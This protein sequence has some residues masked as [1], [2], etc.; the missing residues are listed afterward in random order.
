MPEFEAALEELRRRSQPAPDVPADTTQQFV[1]NQTEIDT[2]QDLNLLRNQT[3]DHPGVQVENPR[4]APKPLSNQELATDSLQNNLRHAA[5]VNPQE[6]ARRRRLANDLGVP[7]ELLPDGPEAQEQL[8]LKE[9]DPVALMK[10]HPTIAAY[11]QDLDNAEVAGQD[12]GTLKKVSNL[13]RRFHLDPLVAAAKTTVAVPQTLAGVYKIYDKAVMSL[14]PDSLIKAVDD[15]TPQAIREGMGNVEDQLAQSG[16]RLDF[17]QTQ[18]FLDKFYSPET[19]AAKESVAKAEGFFGTIVTALENPSAIA[20][21]IGE[22]IGPMLLGGATAQVITKAFPAISPLVAGAAG[23]GVTIAGGTAQQITEETGEA[24]TGKQAAIAAGTGVLGAGIGILGAKIAQKLGVGDLDTALA[25]GTLE[26]AMVKSQVPPGLVK[27]ILVGG[28]LEGMEELGQSGVEQIAQNIATEKPWNEGIPEALAMG[29]LTGGV[30]GG[31]VQAI[32]P[33][34]PEEGLNRDIDD[35][36]VEALR[37]VAHAQQAEENKQ[38]LEEFSKSVA[39]SSL[40]ANSPE[41]FKKF[42]RTMADEGEMIQEVYVD[43]AKLDE[44]FA[45]SG[46]T[47]E[48]L[49]EKM[50]EVAKELALAKEVGSEVRI[51]F[52]DYA[53]HIAG[54]KAEVPLLDHLRTTPEGMTYAESQ[55]FFQGQEKQL[56]EQAKEILETHQPVLSEKEFKAQEPEGSYQK[57]L[58]DHKNKA[59]VFAVDTKNVHQNILDGLNATGRFTK[60]INAVYAVPFREFYATAAA[61]EG[62]LPSELYERMPLNFKNVRIEDG[63]LDQPAGTFTS[64][65]LDNLTQE[66]IKDLLVVQHNLSAE[67]LL[68]A[69]KMGGLAVPSVGIAKA[70]SPLKGFGEITLVGS[71]DLVRPSKDT[72]A[73]GADI[74][75]PRYPKVV[76]DFSVQNVKFLEKEIAQGIEL[77]GEGI[78][79]MQLDDDPVNTLRHNNAVLA[80]YLINIG[81]KPKIVRTKATKSPWPT[82]AKYAK[83]TRPPHVIKADEVFQKAVADTVDRPALLKTEGALG[84]LMT[85]R[86]NDLEVHRQKV[87]DAGKI[88]KMET[89]RALK[90]QVKDTPEFSDYVLGLIERAS[91]QEKLFKGYTY[92]GSRK[93]I[94]HTLDNVIKALKQDIRAAEGFN[95]GLGTARATVTPKFRSVEQIQANRNRIVDTETFEAIKEE[96]NEEFLALAEKVNE[97]HDVARFDTFAEVLTFVAKQG[98]P[99]SLEESGYTN[100]PVELQQEIGAFMDKLKNMPTEYFEVKLLR[101]VSLGEFSGAVVPSNTSDKVLA[102][103]RDN[104]IT[105][106]R[107]YKAGDTDARTKAIAKFNDLFFQNQRTPI[108]EQ[109]PETINVDG[110]ER[111]TT[112]SEGKQIHPT[113]EGV[114]NFWRWFGDSKV[115]DEAGKPLVVYHGTSG[116]FNEFN[117]EFQDPTIRSLGGFHFTSEPK[118]ARGFSAGDGG[119][120]IPVYLSASNLENLSREDIRSI[121]KQ[122]GK[123]G[124]D[125]LVNDKKSEGIDGFIID[126]NHYIVFDPNQIKSAVGNVGT[127]SETDL[128]ILRQSGVR[129][130]TQEE[131]TGRP[132]GPTTVSGIPPIN[133]FEEQTKI[134]GRDGQPLTV[135]RGSDA[136]LQIDHFKKEA[137]GFASGAAPSGRGVHFTTRKSSAA[138][139]GDVRE[140]QLDIRNPF[141]FKA[142]DPKIP[143]HDTAEE[144]FEWREGLRKKG[145]DGIVEIASHLGGPNNIIAFDPEQVILKPQELHQ[146]A[147]QDQTETEEFKNWSSNGEVVESED[148]NDYQFKPNT[149]TVLKV[150]HGTTHDFSVFEA[151]RGNLEG[152]FGAINYFTSSQQD[153]SDNYAGEGPDLTNRIESLSE[154]L[155]D[156][157]QELVEVDFSTLSLEDTLDELASRINSRFDIDLQPQDIPVE[158]ESVNPFALAEDVARRALSG[159]DEL[160]MELFVRVDNPFVIGGGLQFVELSADLQEEARKQVA[161]E[162]GI[163]LDELE[164]NIDD[165]EDA[166][167]ER[168]SELET[169]APNALVE[170]IQKVSSRYEVSAGELL[171]SVYELGAETDTDT[172]EDLLRNSEDYVYAEDPDTGQLVGSQLVAEV[173]KEMGFDSII[174]RNADTRFQGMDMEEGTAHV[175]IFDSGKTNIKS[176]ENVGTFDPTDPDIFRQQPPEQQIRAAYDPTNFTISLLKG[177]D[178]SSVIHE[179]GHFYLEALADMAGQPNAVQ[180]VKDDFRTTLNW[181]G[182][183]GDNPEGVWNMMTLEQK[184][185]YHEQWAQSF[186]RYNLEGKAPT[187]EMQPVFARF[188]AWM[189]Q[190]YKS[191]KEFLKQNPLAGRLNDDIRQVFDRMLAADDA[192]KETEKIREY[193]LLFPTAEAAG[194]SREDFQEYLEAGERA[195]SLAV[196]ELT[197]RSLRDMRWASNAKD[198]AIKALQREARKERKV[199]REQVEAEVMAEPINLARRLIR[200]GELVNQDGTVTKVTEHKLNTEDVKDLRPGM[201]LVGSPL[202]GMTKQGGLNPDLAAQFFGFDSGD[203]LLEALLTE[204]TAEEKINGITDQRMLQE[205][206]D[207]VDPAEVK[208][209]AE[210]A[211]HNEARARFMATGLRLLSKKVGAGMGKDAVNQMARAAKVAA[212][213]AISQKKVRELSPAQFEAAETKANREAIKRAA[214]DPKKALEAQRAALLNNRLARAASEA[215]DEVDSALRYLKKFDSPNVRKQLTPDHLEQIDDLRQNV[216]TRK[217]ITNKQLD[218]RKS[219]QDWI[220]EQ[221]ANGFEPAIDPAVMDDLKRKH[222]KEMTV[223]ELRGLVDSIKQIEHIARRLQKVFTARDKRKFQELVDDAWQSIEDN[224]NRTVPE[225]GT[226]TDVV[227]VS[228]KWARR[229]AAEHRKFNSII[230]EMDGGKDNGKMWNLLS[231]GMNEAGDLETEMKQVATDKMSELFAKLPKEKVVPG[232]IY[233]KKKVIPGTNL[234]MTQEQRIMFGMNWGNAGNRQRLLDGGITGQRAISTKEAD[235]VLDTLTKEEWDFIQGVWDYIA[236]YKPQV[237]ALEK[238]LTGV[239]PEWVEPAPVKTKFG[240]YRGGYFPAKYDTELST[241]SE[242]LEAVTDLR[243]GMKGAFGSAATRSGYTKARADEVKNRPLLL[244]YN[245]ISQH[246]S[247]VTHRLS[248]QPWLIDANR[249]LKALDTPIRKHYGP[250]ILKELRDTA[251]DIAQGD[252]PA[253]N[254]TEQAINRLRTGSTIVGLGWRVSTAILQVTG[255]TQSMARIGSRWAAVGVGKYVASPIDSAKF[256]DE[257]S[258][259]MRDRSKTMNREINEILNTIRAGEKVSAF[260]ATYFTMIGKMQ[261]IVDLPTWHGAYEK[262]LHQ[263]KYENALD[264]KARKEIEDHA[265]ALADQA[266]IDSQS[267]GH[268]KDLAKIQRGSPAWKLFTNFY[269]YFS[270]AYN[271]NIEAVRRT[272]FKS[273]S[274]VGLFAVDMMLINTV[275]T[276][277]AT[278]LALAMKGGCDWE[279]IECVGKK[280]AQDQ[281]GHFMGQIILL[282]EMGAAISVATGGDGYGYQGPAGLRFF[283]DLYKAGIQINQGEADMALFKAVNSTAGAILHYPAGQINSTVDGIRA[284]ERGEV[285]GIQILPALISG[286]PR[287]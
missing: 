120:I 102:V 246:V 125:K 79:R 182:I 130:A 21:A 228:A 42:I 167:Y 91:P 29:L 217:G 230:R 97:H 254:A 18:E 222:Y 87:R 95:Y 208:R 193:S 252:A 203:A 81:K 261:R 63:I 229:M 179:G 152:Q 278:A 204:E 85:S 107:K 84:R 60:D 109:L 118:R 46:I 116:D 93:Y 282:R 124:A 247:E 123:Y 244:S 54:S 75:S 72:Q 188:R 38:T 115:V 237:A 256:A 243:M 257:K 139:H 67:N 32:T 142:D 1:P 216:D 119:N 143:S 241:R 279:D 71:K 149:P 269:S 266:V 39:E 27:K 210:K 134:R 262:A 283:S 280:L 45:Q 189:L 135:F 255:L 19:R 234:S 56:T 201:P 162:E 151:K 121:N 2:E 220:D 207:L 30:M 170:A 211:V 50:P 88:D 148:I 233:S 61:K 173:I 276:V 259:L 183:N 195:T 78:D 43:A 127:F 89:E 25:T 218:K 209:A 268:I 284:I 10:S 158:D 226:P 163:S 221:E 180:Q 117:I 219:L 17:K 48:E 271:L 141:V 273:P 62:I 232:N 35:A 111:S 65:D 157:F 286:P 154:K 22:S 36:A 287:D 69:H 76:Y 277:M 223:E 169:D 184:R 92:S 14:I 187:T 267:G 239:E 114:E 132:G 153:A 176:V 3:S 94:P 33:K 212:E 122:Y 26:G 24:L 249:L 215:K 202:S 159:G 77:T 145:F 6:V 129:D 74:Y 272:N 235:K 52:D 100:V 285:E 136:G 199:I 104:G 133:G 31:T 281:L 275:P 99:K 214:K 166:V 161:E 245:V 250:E 49:Q 156:E 113:R 190:V 236:T 4:P 144:Y 83:D 11:L 137:L 101:A 70:K 251:I 105:D 68:H 64:A 206:G 80:Q 90:K 150:F 86:L 263:L 12:I 238:K 177:A 73:F 41:E 37:N 231:R 172:L 23:E 128:N 9:N 5:G 146:S 140:F 106:I 227:G 20:T 185:Q 66:E 191:M 108:P 253:K 175:H 224:A 205:H 147:Q 192:I 8:F 160:V 196:D 40:R 200:K 131:F 110:V 178:L 258:K 55:Q 181:F 198:R 270:A 274:E 53:T 28:G 248:W 265:V 103:L 98:V 225:R 112:N 186:E 260:T 240:T 174:L 13:M 34:A 164:E 96:M 242:S 15:A 58:K 197:A 194:A 171:S 138:V 155:G 213:T 44:A 51:S 16:I 126:G 57:Y 7:K 168:L 59:E 82:L 264:E 47:P 165:Y